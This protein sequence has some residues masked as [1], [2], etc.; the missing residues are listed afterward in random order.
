MAWPIHADL[1]IVD[2]QMRARLQCGED[3]GMGQL[4]TGRIAGRVVEVHAEHLTDFE[5]VA[6]VVVEHANAQFRALKVGEDGD[7]LVHDGSSD[8]FLFND[9]KQQ[10]N[11]PLLLIIHEARSKT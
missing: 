11:T 2:E 7:R 1:A 5:I 10:V 8:L 6:F 9:E 4:H 3:L